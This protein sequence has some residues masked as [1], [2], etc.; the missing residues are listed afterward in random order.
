ML[1][2]KEYRKLRGFTQQELSELSGI[3]KRTL[4]NYE[5][6]DSDIPFSKLQKI[7]NILEVSIQELYLDSTTEMVNDPLQKYGA[8]CKSCDEKIELIK[9]L[10]KTITSQEALIEM[11]KKQG[12]GQSS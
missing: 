8:D 2:I 7:A 4:I 5:N 1:K 10:Q 9:A 3:K 6:G 12:K 11:L